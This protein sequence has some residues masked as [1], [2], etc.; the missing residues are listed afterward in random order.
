M[1]IDCL[2]FVTLVNELLLAPSLKWTCKTPSTHLPVPLLHEEGR[3]CGVAPRN[4]SCYFW[5]RWYE[6]TN[7]EITTP[8]ETWIALSYIIKLKNCLLFISWSSIWVAFQENATSGSWSYAQI[9]C[10]FLLHYCDWL[11][12]RKCHGGISSVLCSPVPIVLCK[13]DVDPDFKR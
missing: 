1:C 2:A 10:P 7:E 12:H 3:S 13:T 4:L 5:L 11:S 6:G 8:L 9:S